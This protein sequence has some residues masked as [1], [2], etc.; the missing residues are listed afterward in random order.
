MTTLAE[1][2]KRLPELQS[3]PRRHSLFADLGRTRQVNGEAYAI[4]VQFWKRLVQR[5]LDQ[6][7]L[8]VENPGGEQDV[9]RNIHGHTP[10]VIT[11]QSRLTFT[12][13]HLRHLYTWQG[14]APLGLGAVIRDMEGSGEI[15]SLGDFYATPAARWS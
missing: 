5:T 11:D 7:W 1:H 12:L 15:M 6:G 4:N 2:L 9:P 8:V 13:D 3:E 10:L 14:E